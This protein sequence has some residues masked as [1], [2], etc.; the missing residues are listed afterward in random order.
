LE[1]TLHIVSLILLQPKWL[2]NHYFSSP[3]A[4]EK[5]LQ[6]VRPEGSKMFYVSNVL[7]H[8]VSSACMEMNFFHACICTPNVYTK[9]NT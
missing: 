8:V 4:E 1:S 9:P 3:I 2:T 5:H 7:W 6:S